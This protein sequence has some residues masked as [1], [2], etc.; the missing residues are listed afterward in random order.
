MLKHLMH[1]LKNEWFLQEVALEYDTLVFSGML[2]ILYIHILCFILYAAL[3]LENLILKKVL[4]KY[5]GII[6]RIKDMVIS[7]IKTTLY[8]T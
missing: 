6:V 5:H 7:L 2:V 3:D 1:K 8:R 4:Q